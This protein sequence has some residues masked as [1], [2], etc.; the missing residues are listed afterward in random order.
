MYL[1]IF[2]FF[3]YLIL[4]KSFENSTSSL[5]E[6]FGQISLQVHIYMCKRFTD[7]LAG[8]NI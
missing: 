4:I 2:N 1:L 5:F 8:Q 7:G 6:L 3:K